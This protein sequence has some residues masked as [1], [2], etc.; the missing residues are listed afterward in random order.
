MGVTDAVTGRPVGDTGPVWSLDSMLELQRKVADFGLHLTVIELIPISDRVKLGL[1]GRDEEIDHF[2]QTVRNLGHAG[3]RVMAYNWMVGFTWFRTSVATPVRGDA[4]STAYNHEVMQNLPPAALGEIHPE[5]L[6]AGL[7]YFLQAV[8]P[9]AEESGVQL[10]IH[11]DD[12]PLSPVRGVPRILT[13]PM[14]L[15]RVIDLVP[16][17]AN[18]LTFCQG[19]FGEMGVDVPTY[20]RHFGK[21]R[22]IFFAHFRNIRGTAEDFVETF[23]DDGQLDMFEAMQA[24][25]EIGFAGPMRPDHAPTMEG[26][27]NE[28]PGYAVQGRILAI[29]YMRG[30]LEAIEKSK[31]IKMGAD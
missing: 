9:V 6:W 30:L 22:K 27:S 29:G 28:N 13:S 4:L 17:E 18:G 24:Y 20:I 14:A 16:S 12:P 1:R 31:L 19:C 21:Q 10:A 23:H 5:Q 25:H 3:I 2:C 7:E 11:P 8:V 15:Q 26:E